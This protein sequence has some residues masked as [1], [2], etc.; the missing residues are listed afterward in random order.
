M[1][2]GGSRARGK[3]SVIVQMD[4]ITRMVELDDRDIEMCGLVRDVERR[5]QLLAACP[6]LKDTLDHVEQDIESH[7]EA[8]AGVAGFRP[9][10]V[11]WLAHMFNR[12]AGA[13]V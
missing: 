11:V 1:P 6:G 7:I 12:V 3:Q 4:E 13:E 2:A 9:Q 8:A 10:L 5:Q